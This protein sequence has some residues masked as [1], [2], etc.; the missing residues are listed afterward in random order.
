MDYR[1]FMEAVAQERER[2]PDD[3][4]ENAI[5]EA[6]AITSGRGL[7]RVYSSRR[8][9]TSSGMGMGVNNGSE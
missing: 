4:K 5:G 1:L 2:N 9:I 6:A 7:Q 3:G 8:R